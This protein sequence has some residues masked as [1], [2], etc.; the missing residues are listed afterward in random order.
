MIKQLVI[1]LSAL[2]LLSLAPVPPALPR[3]TIAAVPHT[4]AIVARE[5]RAPRPIYQLRM[6]IVHGTQPCAYDT[7]P[8]RLSA[9]IVDPIGY[10]YGMAQAWSC[11][12]DGLAV[13]NELAARV[14]AMDQEAAAYRA[15]HPIVGVTK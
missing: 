12:G 8:A 1:C 2:L 3:A 7:A 14:A 15:S 5:R 9:A 10:P 6:A 4:A 11:T 13:A